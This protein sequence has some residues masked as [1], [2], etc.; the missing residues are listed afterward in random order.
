[1]GGF[2]AS[3][4]ALQHPDRVSHVILADPWGFPDRP[5]GN[6]SNSRIRIPP[7]VKGIAYLLQPFNPLWLIRVSGRLGSFTLLLAVLCYPAYCQIVNQ[8]YLYQI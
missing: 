4:Y 7:W 2:L 5:S 1:M 6:D 3:A 8:I